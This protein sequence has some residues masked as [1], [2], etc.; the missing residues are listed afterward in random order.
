MRIV[1]L[2]CLKI[3]YLILTLIC[4]YVSLPT[5]MLPVLQ[6]LFCELS[7]EISQ[8]YL[9][10]VKIW[11]TKLAVNLYCRF[12]LI[13]QNANLRCE[14]D[15]KFHR[16]LST[17]IHLRHKSILLKDVLC[18]E[19]HKNRNRIFLL[20]LKTPLMQSRQAA[21]HFMDLHVAG[22]GSS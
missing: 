14:L 19:L 6:S 2:P 20:E 8:Y 17:V 12:I 18:T 4:L 22:N 3:K 15:G 16:N 11:V 21:D 5:G 7:S 9:S 10:G 1:Y 13:V